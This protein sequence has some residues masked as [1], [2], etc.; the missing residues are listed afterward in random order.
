MTSHM[1]N[2][3]PRNKCDVKGCIF[4]Q[5]STLDKITIIF[6]AQIVAMLAKHYVEFFGEFINNKL[7]ASVIYFIILLYYIRQVNDRIT[8]F[9]Y[10][11]KYS[12]YVCLRRPV[13]F[14]GRLIKDPSR[15]RMPV[16]SPRLAFEPIKQAIQDLVTLFR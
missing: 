5:N 14:R 1:L 10:H 12:I 16:P 13:R 6:I 15:D 9:F 4:Q 8:C 3:R 2:D 11:A 7:V